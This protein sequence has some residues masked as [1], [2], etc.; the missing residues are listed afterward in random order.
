METPR[1]A[2]CKYCTTVQFLP[3]PLWLS[4]HPVKIKQAWY[5]RSSYKDRK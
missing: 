3:D 1:N 5:I 4:L 2:T